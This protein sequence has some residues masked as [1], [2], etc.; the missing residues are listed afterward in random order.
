MTL[1]PAA[2]ASCI[3]I[4]PTE[5]EPPYTTSVLPK[6][7]AGPSNEGYGSPS[8]GV[9]MPGM[10]EPRSLRESAQT[11]ASKANGI[12]TPSMNEIASGK[13]AA[14]SAGMAVYKAKAPS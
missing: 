2:V 13:M 10:T 14:L 9:E 7:H 4:E 11:A 5:D 1:I 12:T 6:E 3:V 8:A